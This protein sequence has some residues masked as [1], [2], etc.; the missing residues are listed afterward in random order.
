M[1]QSKSPYT[2]QLAGQLVEIPFQMLHH[3]WS[4]KPLSVA[5]EHRF[6]PAWRQYLLLWAPPEN[7]PVRN[8]VVVIYHGGGWR[9]G[10]P[11]LFPTTA[12]FF[13]KQGFPVIMPAYRLAPWARHRQMRD[14]LNLALLKTLRL[15]EEKGWGGKKLIAGGISAGATLAAHLVFNRQELR[16]MDLDQNIF[17]G[18]LSVAGPLDLDAMPDFGAVRGYAGG[19]PGSV[20]F[21]EANPVN[22]LT[23]DESVPVLLIHSLTDAIVPIASARS[24][25]QKYNGPK[26]LYLLKNKT[27]LGTMRFATD[28]GDTAR[29]LHNWLADK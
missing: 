21:H 5:E 2:V 26:D 1:A 13:L 6:G 16:N 22:L 18:F 14:D 27:H 28:D 15:L 12:E 8:S 7:C 23:P 3:L 11:G 10:W 19:K 24:F 9:V 4:S 20:D 29:V 25:Y 17:S